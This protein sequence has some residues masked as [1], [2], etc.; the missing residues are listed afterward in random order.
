LQEL[1]RFD[2]TNGAARIWEV[3]EARRAA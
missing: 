1:E 3:I 2:G